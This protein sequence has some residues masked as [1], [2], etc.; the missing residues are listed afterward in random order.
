M[1]LGE[2][3]EFSPNTTLRSLVLRSVTDFG[4]SLVEVLESVSSPLEHLTLGDVQEM[5]EEIWPSLVDVLMSPSYASLV[6][7][8]FLVNNF[9]KGVEQLRTDISSEYPEFFERGI[10][11][12][13]LCSFDVRII[14]LLTPPRV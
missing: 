1:F 5:D 13:G 2:G 7:V 11:V 14:T 9:E 12:F 10:A 6:K 8:N 4:I 3:L